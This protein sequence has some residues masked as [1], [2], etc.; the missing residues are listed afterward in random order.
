MVVGVEVGSGVKVGVE[1]D[2]E[3]GVE[4]G[5]RVGV[6]V[7]VGVGIGVEVGSKVAASL[8][9]SRVEFSPYVKLGMSQQRPLAVAMLLD[10]GVKTDA[11]VPRITTVASYTMG[12]VTGDA[13]GDLTIRNSA[14]NWGVE[15]G[16][17]KDISRHFCI[18]AEARVAI[19]QYWKS[20]V[21]GF[22]GLLNF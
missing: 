5:V 3:V 19:S 16:V 22:G 10:I 18:V 6:G 4:V 17:E 11:G 20:C 12:K 21:M 2:V 13:A 15:L 1:V 8:F 7:G 14:R 9:Y